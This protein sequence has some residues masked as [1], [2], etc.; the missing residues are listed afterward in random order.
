VGLKSETKIGIRPDLV[1]DDIR[2]GTGA[3]NLSPFLAGYQRIGV[4]GR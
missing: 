3:H 2:G 1:V 4:V